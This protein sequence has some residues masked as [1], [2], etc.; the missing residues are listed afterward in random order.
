MGTSSF[1]TKRQLKDEKNGEGKP[2]VGNIATEYGNKMESVAL[3]KVSELLRIDLDPC[4]WVNGEYSA[5]LD[6]YGVDDEGW[7]V[8]VEIKCPFQKTKSKLWKTVE[9]DEIP[10]QYYWQLVHQDMTVP[11]DRSYFFVYIDDDN[12][13][14]LP[15]VMNQGDDEWLKDAWDEF[16]EWNPEPEF[17]ERTDEEFG[18]LVNLHKVKLMEK[19]RV[20][21]QLKE[22]ETELKALCEAPS[23]GFGCTISTVER[24][25]S[26]DYKAIPELK[27][28]DLEPYRKDSTTY[29]VIKHDKGDNSE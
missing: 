18:T 12:Y 17:I 28:L 22:L 7:S 4:V 25:G 8:K 5:S 19:K 10:D 14:L 6:A 29:Q 1:M 11:T 2:F 16:E 24:K 9:K 15:F 27:G 21:D 13:V 20:D 23:R 26:V 3:A